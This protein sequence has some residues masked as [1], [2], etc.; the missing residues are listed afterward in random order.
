MKRVQDKIDR[1]EPVSSI[2]DDIERMSHHKN[3]LEFINILF[4]ITESLL[5]K[6]LNNNKPCGKNIC[7]Y[8]R[9]NSDTIINVQK[10]QKAI[11]IRH[12]TTH[13]LLIRDII[14]TDFTIN[15]FI[16]YIRILAY[17]N[18]VDLDKFIFSHRVEKVSTE[19]SLVP[20]IT[21]IVIVGVV[22]LF[23]IF[24]FYFNREITTKFLTGS[25][26]GTYYLTAQDIKKSIAHDMLVLES[27]G[28]MGNMKRIGLSQ[29]DEQIFAFVQNDVLQYLSEEARSGDKE[30]QK[31]LNKT[32]V[33]M[34]SYDGEIHILVRE[35]NLDIKHFKDLKDKKI[36]IGMYNSG[37][38][39]TAKSL[40]FKLFHEEI[41]KIYQAF[42]EA[43]KALTDKS[44]DAI[45]LTGG[46]PLSKLN[47]KISKVR[48]ISYQGDLVEGYSISY[49]KKDSYPWLKQEKIRTLSVKSFIVTNITSNKDNLN[50]LKEF[51]E[52]LKEYKVNLRKDN[53]SKPMHPKLEDFAKNRCLPTLPK[54]LEY[55]QF[56]KWNT[57]WCKKE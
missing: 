2:I 6:I 29:A 19:K 47:K 53:H 17:E 22:V 26:T 13:D 18:R 5:K 10:I 39:I 8:Q 14:K 4:S 55:H 23:L 7:L 38:A 25:S 32:K 27:E 9:K 40:Y 33:L 21:K 42:D 57:P 24:L 34:P 20:K 3:P 36:S 52:K 35:E 46:Q 51:L 37:T 16:K 45:V 30:K 1:G 11:T 31:I 49:I 12:E 41:N 56:V 28:S 44:V 48:L 54:G 43:L 50:Y 15:T